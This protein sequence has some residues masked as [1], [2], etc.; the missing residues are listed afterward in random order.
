MNEQNLQEVVKQK[1]GAAAKDSDSTGS[2]Q[3]DENGVENE[4][5]EVRKTAPERPAHRCDCPPG[6]V[7][8]PCCA[9]A[10]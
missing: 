7:G 9:P 3:D 5:A 10:A 2:G 1:Y 4:H 6:C 8:L